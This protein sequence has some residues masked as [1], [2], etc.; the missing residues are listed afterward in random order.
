MPLAQTHVIIESEAAGVVAAIDEG[1]RALRARDYDRLLTMLGQ[2]EQS[3]SHVATNCLW[4]MFE[5]SE[6]EGFLCE[7]DFF[8]HR[9]RPYIS[10][11]TALFEGQYESTERL[12]ELEEELATTRSDSV[13]C[14]WPSTRCSLPTR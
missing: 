3:M 5:R 10:T 8:F 12:A 14:S 1:V 6:T 9:F 7:P 11:W 4:I 2:L 13:S